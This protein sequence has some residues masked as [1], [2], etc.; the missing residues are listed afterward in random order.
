MKRLPESSIDR[1]L[2]AQTF[3]S[4]I[5]DENLDPAEANPIIADNWATLQVRSKIES[6]ENRKSKSVTWSHVNQMIPTN[7]TYDHTAN[8]VRTIFTFCF[9]G[10]EVRGSDLLYCLF[11]EWQRTWLDWR[12]ETHHRTTR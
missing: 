3:S 10:L 9:F 8:E 11:R 1:D 12:Q 6:R 7:P 4:L 5:C 2:K